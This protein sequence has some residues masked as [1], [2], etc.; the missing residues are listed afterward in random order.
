MI[1]GLTDSDKYVYHYTSSE[2]ATQFILKDRSLR[3]GRFT[4]TN[5]PKESKDWAFSF[6]TN[7]NRD[8]GRY[9]T[10]YSRLV[11][12]SIKGGTRLACFSMDG[13]LTGSH[14]QDI[15]NR[16]FA[17]PRM[18]AQYGNNHHGVCLVLKRNKLD[19][20][21]VASFSKHVVLRGRVKYTN[22]PLLEGPD[23]HDYQINIDALEDLGL[24]QYAKLHVQHY[25]RRLFL[26][27]MTDWRDEAEY[28][29]I[30]FADTR[31]ELYVP[32]DECLEGLI[33]GEAT[34]IRD[35]KTM[36][37][38]AE[39]IGAQCMRLKWRNC[40]PWYDF[41]DLRYCPGIKGSPWSKYIT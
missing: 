27:K 1:L 10:A 30:V 38:L 7:E 28:R 13:S 2:T 29:W 16:G 39:P 24:Q 8:L 19:R 33:F 23:D 15:C 40:A 22:R 5:D 18:W 17:K 21:I 12:E 32:L 6:G 41:G 3:F 4:N 20:A 37:E 36:M 14:M 26:E 9:N 35:I 11:S 31:D 34:T 25:F